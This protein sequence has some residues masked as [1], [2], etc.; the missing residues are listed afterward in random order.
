VA[1]VL[2]A[3]P[4]ALVA[5]S[6][7]AFYQSCACDQLKIEEYGW[8]PHVL[9]NYGVYLSWIA[10]PARET[11]LSPDAT[12][13]AIAGAVAALC[14]WFALRGPHIARIGAAGMVLALLPFVPVEIWTASRYTYG[15]VALVAPVAAVGACAVFDRARA[16]T[17]RARAP[18]TVAALLLVA[19]IAALNAW[20]THAQHQ[21]SGASG[22]RWRLLARELRVNYADVPDG[23]TIYIVGGPWQ[24]PMENYAW[25]PSVARAL[26]GDAAAFNIAPGADEPDP[27]DHGHEVF[28]EWRDRGLHP[29]YGAPAEISAGGRASGR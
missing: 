14:G 27:A 10:A 3:V 22:E 19:T 5:S 7:L 28:L 2:H 26:Y 1:L 8:G 4:F 11:P 13:W 23:T 6:W 20:Q 24:N 12:R 9:R 21:R 18:V 29:P 17:P 15:A 16:V 25:V